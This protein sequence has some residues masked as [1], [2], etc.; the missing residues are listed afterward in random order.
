MKPIKRTP[1][2]NLDPVDPNVEQA[3]DAFLQSLSQVAWPVKKPKAKRPRPTGNTSIERDIRKQ[4]RKA[5]GARRKVIDE[6][7]LDTEKRT[8]QYE[9]EL[10]PALWDN[11]SKVREF[12]L[13][14][15]NPLVFASSLGSAQARDVVQRV[16]QTNVDQEPYHYFDN[17][18]RK[19]IRLKLQQFVAQYANVDSKDLANLV[20]KVVLLNEQP[21][22]RITKRVPR[23][24]RGTAADESDSPQKSNTN[25]QRRSKSRHL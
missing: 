15:I 23:S 5:K 8:G 11:V 10:S 18:M 9:G 17:L 22:E 24:I 14:E 7:E 6:L 12:F 20:E 1:K 16:L 2:L 4:Q 13:S 21:R 3:T 25:V 19:A